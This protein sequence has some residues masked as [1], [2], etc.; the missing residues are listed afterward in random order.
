[1]VSELCPE[2]VRYWV[3][4]AAVGS[5]AT[6]PEHPEVA[7]KGCGVPFARMVVGET[8]H[9]DRVTLA[10]GPELATIIWAISF[11]LAVIENDPWLTE[12]LVSPA[13]EAVIRAE[14]VPA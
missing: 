13:Y 3:L 7:W 2:A 10:T 11:T 5:V 8:E 9:P 1:M 6:I 14:T 12:L 4:A